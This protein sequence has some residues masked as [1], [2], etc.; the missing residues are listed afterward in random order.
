MAA[1]FQSILN[2]FQG[3]NKYIAKQK[4]DKE[5]FICFWQGF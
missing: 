1:I 2:Y 5:R 3:K 4:S